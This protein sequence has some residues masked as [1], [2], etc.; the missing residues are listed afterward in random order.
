MTDSLP[1]RPTQAARPGVTRRNLLRLGGAAI[2]AA[3]LLGRGATPA[4]A[5]STPQYLTERKKSM[6]LTWMGHS[7]IRIEQD[8]FVTVIDPGVLSAPDAAAGAD[9]LLISHRHLDHYDTSKIAA[10]VAAKPG[11]QIW[12]NR[13]VA[14]LLEQSGAASGARLHV[15]GHG[16]AFEAGGLRV[17]C[18]GE[19]HAP[20]YPSIPQV[21]NTGF[22]VDGRLFHPGDAFTDPGVPIELLLLQ[23]IGFYTKT[24]LS[25]DY[26]RQ[27]RPSRVAPIHDATLTPAGQQGEDAVFSADPPTGLGTGV[28]YF[29]PTQGVPFDF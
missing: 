25:A 24:S 14:T 1:A 21:R 27:L 15:I 8:G 11:L 29:R 3:A 26:V 12:T 16:D 4:E 19:W 20:I 17:H 13:E 28:P 9:A 5:A 2:P 10:A 18:Y 7:C 22:L 6:Q 23:L